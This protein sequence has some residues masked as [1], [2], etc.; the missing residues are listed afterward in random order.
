MSLSLFIARRLYGSK[1]NT[2]RLSSLGVNIATIGIAIGLAIM[3]VS[4]AVVLGFKDEIK[5][6]VTGFGSH[7]QILNTDAQQMCDTLP[8]IAGASFLDRLSKC[9]GVSHVQRVTQKAGIL[10]TDADFQGIS[11]T[12]IGEDYDTTFLAQHLVEGKLPKQPTPDPSQGEGSSNPDLLISRDIADALSLHCGDKVFA[13]FFSSDI[14][15]RRFVVCGIYQTNMTQFDSNTAFASLPVV[16]ALNGWDSLSCSTLEIMVKDFS[17]VEEIA[18]RVAT[19]KPDVPDRNGCYYAVYTISELYG[20]IFDWLKLLDLNIWV[21]LGLMT[22]VCCFTMIS[23]LLILILERTS[24]IGILK[25]L[26][27]RNSMVRRVFL[28]YG[29]FIIGRGLVLG[30]AIGLA[31][32]YVQWQWHIFPLDASSYYVDH[33]P[34]TFNWLAIVAL[35]IS[36]LVICTLILVGPTLVVSHIKPVKALKF[37]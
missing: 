13:Y 15:M 12:G 3:I 4:V 17:Q 18:D 30:N 16:N 5:S 37:D 8:V 34:V 32:C 20:A 19:L 28:H 35:N 21:I 22:C 10:K 26:G 14:R 11:F 29:V 1:E 31:L 23:G 24:T 2:G 25:A 27:G 33:V 36:T 6:K 7:I 9:E